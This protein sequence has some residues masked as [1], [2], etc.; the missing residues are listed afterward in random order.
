MDRISIFILVGVSLN[1]PM[2]MCL[3]WLMRV[4]F[5]IEVIGQECYVVCDG[6]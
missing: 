4:R 2:L 3:S 5:G 6:N 1:L